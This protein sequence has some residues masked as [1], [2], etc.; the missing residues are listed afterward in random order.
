SGREI[1][2]TPVFRI[3]NADVPLSSD[4]VHFCPGTNG[5]SE[6]NGPAYDGADNLIVTGSVDWCVTVTLQ[7]SAVTLAQPFWKPWTG[8]ADQANLYGKF[9]PVSQ[10]VGWVYGTD[11]DTGTV[12]WR[13]QTPGPVV[14][15]VTATA[16]R[17]V[18][19]GDID[20]NQYALDARSGQ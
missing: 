4:P 6:W 12:V 8:S 14:G 20:G 5:G 7:P 19:V 10:R 11:A 1:Y 2:K 13:F 15:G 18:F 9:D 16:G 3:E 17:L